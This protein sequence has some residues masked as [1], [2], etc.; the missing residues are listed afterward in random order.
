MRI[1]LRRPKLSTPSS[2]LQQVARNL[3]NGG[4][5][6][7]AVSGTVSGLAFSKITKPDLFALRSKHVGRNSLSVLRPTRANCSSIQQITKAFAVQV[8]SLS[9]SESPSR[10]RGLNFTC[11]TLIAARCC[12]RPVVLR[13]LAGI[14]SLAVLVQPIL[15]PEAS[16]AQLASYT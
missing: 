14:V 1:I 9:D 12:Y 5:I 15:V 11:A 7:R 2:L 3:W 13:I 6:R 10:G 4:P 16:T 8:F